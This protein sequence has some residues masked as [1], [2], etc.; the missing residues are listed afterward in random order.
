MADHLECRESLEAGEQAVA[1][2]L[3]EFEKLLFV[4]TSSCRLLS[5]KLGEQGRPAKTRL[6]SASEPQLHLSSTRLV[7]MDY[8]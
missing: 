7:Q 8:I 1:G 6:I 4:Y 2:C 5:F 3:D